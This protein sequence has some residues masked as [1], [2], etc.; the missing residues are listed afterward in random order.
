MQV[1]LVVLKNQATQV[2]EH[3][4][5]ERPAHDTHLPPDNTETLAMQT[6]AVLTTQLPLT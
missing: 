3:E 1:E 4:E 6:E 5:E 2:E